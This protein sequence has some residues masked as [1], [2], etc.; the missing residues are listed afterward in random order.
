MNKLAMSNRKLNPGMFKFYLEGLYR[1]IPAGVV[2]FLGLRGFES[3]E[4]L[5][6]MGL[7]LT[8]VWMSGFQGESCYPTIW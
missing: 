1:H 5:N 8:L 4:C 3:G 2:V 7:D 6:I